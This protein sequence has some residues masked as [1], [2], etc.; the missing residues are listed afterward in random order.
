MGGGSTIHGGSCSCRDVDWACV[1][2]DFGLTQEDE[3]CGPAAPSEFAQQF[4]VVAWRNL[5]LRLRSWVLLLLELL[6]PAVIIAALGGIKSA[7]G[8]YIYRDLNASNYRHGSSLE[9]LFLVD[10]PLC[11]DRCAG[12]RR[13]R[14]YPRPLIRRFPPCPPRPPGSNLVW[15]CAM[16]LACRRMPEGDQLLAK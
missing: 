11:T 16:P 15:S 2:D 10:A 13:E 3:S 9:D 4:R 5:R 7:V 14:S 6:V 1:R 12:A 8:V